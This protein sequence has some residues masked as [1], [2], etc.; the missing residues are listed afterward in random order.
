MCLLAYLLWHL[1][2][3]VRPG[4]VFA[5]YLVGSGLERF[6]VELVRRNKE[7]LVGLT[8]PQIESL[9]LLAIGLLWLASM[10]RRGGVG[11]LR[12]AAA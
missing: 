7:V 8:A 12:A 3:R 4:V 1:R 6:L 10:L 9:V 2:D 5:L 11:A